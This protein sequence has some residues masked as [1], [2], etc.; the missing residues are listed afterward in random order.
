MN[1]IPLYDWLINR[2]ILIIFLNIHYF[3]TANIHPIIA[4]TRSARIGET[5]IYSFIFISI[6]VI[7]FDWI[8]SNELESLIVFRFGISIYHSI[9]QYQTRKSYDMRIPETIS[10]RSDGC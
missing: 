7:D 2:E 4:H 10:F 3:I 8:F 6:L 5:S 9:I 1:T